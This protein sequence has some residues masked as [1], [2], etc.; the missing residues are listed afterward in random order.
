MTNGEK[1]LRLGVYAGLAAVKLGDHSYA[2][3]FLGRRI[4]D[5]SE[6]EYLQ[7]TTEIQHKLVAAGIIQPD[8]DPFDEVI[9]ELGETPILVVKT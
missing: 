6:A 8:E 4:A 9:Q 7:V 1:A 5:V 2:Q 3:R